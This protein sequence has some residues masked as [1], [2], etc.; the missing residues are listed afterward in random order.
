MKKTENPRRQALRR[1][2]HRPALRHGQGRDAQGDRRRR[3]AAD[4]SSKYDFTDVMVESIQWSGSSGGDDTPTES[5]SFAFAQGRRSRTTSPG[6][7]RRA[8]WATAR[9][10][11]WDLTKAR[12]SDRDA[13]AGDASIERPSASSPR[14]GAA[15]VPLAARSPRPGRDRS[16]RAVGLRLEPRNRAMN[17]SELYKAGRLAR[18]STPRSR[19]S[20][21]TPP[22]RRSGCSSSS[23][24]PSRRP[25]PRPPADRRDRVRRQ[26][27]RAAPSTSY[28]KLL[29]AE[30]ARREL[31]ADGVAAG[32]LRRA[33]RAPAAPAR[34]R[35]PAP[36]GPPRRG[37]RA[38]RPRPT[39]PPRRPR[40]RS[41]ARPSSRSATPTTS[42]AASS[43]S[44]PRGDT[45]GSASS[46]S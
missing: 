34:G 8:P 43:R 11:S 9:N 37:R 18:R 33:V 5:V 32:V 28:R 10:A 41:T 25:R 23:C 2:L 26:R 36:R 44:W 17:A 3:R 27:P 38:A 19:R 12:R 7:R 29:D 42:S 40:A 15:S 6:R 4:R 31:F 46:R 45:S 21:P 13:R 39:R 35:R 24:S 22:T 30:E 14:R 1:L 16:L 20:R